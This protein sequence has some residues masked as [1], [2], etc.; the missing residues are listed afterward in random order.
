MEQQV[1]QGPPSAFTFNILLNDLK[2]GANTVIIKGTD[3]YNTAGTKTL[4]INK[5]H[6]ATVA[7]TAVARYQIQAPTGSAKSILLWVTRTLSNL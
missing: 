1:Y 3:I 6:D 4:T 2:V 7:N 5:T